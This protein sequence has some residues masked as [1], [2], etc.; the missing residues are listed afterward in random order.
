M[1][2]IWGNNIVIE[3]ANVRMFGEVYNVKHTHWPNYTEFTVSM[4][5]TGY[6]SVT[7]R[8]MNER[9]ERL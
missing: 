3:Y 6:E 7:Y 4:R 9:G 1:A 5:V 2:Q 8:E